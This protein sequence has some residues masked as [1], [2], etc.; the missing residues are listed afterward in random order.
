ML[1]PKL[2]ISF[3]IG[4]FGWLYS[5]CKSSD[6]RASRG[7]TYSPHIFTTSVTP[8]AWSHISR[9]FRLCLFSFPD[10]RHSLGHVFCPS[11]P[12]LGVALIF[13]KQ[14]KWWMKTYFDCTKLFDCTVATLR[15]GGGFH[16]AIAQRAGLF[17]W[18]YRKIDRKIYIH[19]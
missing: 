13:T 10:A 9:S 7:S 11:V 19:I 5:W 6:E 17:A 18:K 12:T 8:A 1:K 15:I 4:H 16:V 14:M 3:F 2:N